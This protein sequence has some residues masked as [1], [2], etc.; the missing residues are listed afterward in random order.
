MYK[1]VRETNEK[2]IEY[3]KSYMVNRISYNLLQH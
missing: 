3:R 2:P 1:F